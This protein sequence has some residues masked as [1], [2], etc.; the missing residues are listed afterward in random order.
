[1]GLKPTYGRVSR[2]GLIAYASSFDQ[3][4]IFGNNIEDVARTLEIISGPD[5]Y[6]STAIQLKDNV[7]SLKKKA[8]ENGNGESRNGSSGSEN[9][10]RYDG[11]R[12]DFH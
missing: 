4:G 1:V 2:Y 5:A 11:G 12:T 6:D 3:V 10:S 7:H 8:A 9:R